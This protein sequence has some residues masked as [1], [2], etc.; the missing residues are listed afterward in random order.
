MRVVTL[1]RAMAD[2]RD[3]A[4]KHQQPVRVSVIGV[5]S[6]GKEHARIYADMAAAGAVEFAG[7]YD[8]K[9]ETTRA[10]AEQFR[11]RAFRSL[12]EAAQYSDAL[13]SHAHDNS[14][15]YREAAAGMRKTSVD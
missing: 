14:L 4:K 13:Y 6:L 9:P 11:V 5:G 12:E 8:T 1:R 3:V 10:Y 15:R 7:V 2:W